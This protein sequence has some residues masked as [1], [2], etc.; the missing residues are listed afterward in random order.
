MLSKRKVDMTDGI[1]PG[2]DRISS[3]VAG[4]GSV[5]S[6]AVPGNLRIFIRN[7]RVMNFIDMFIVVLLIYAVFIGLRRGLIL[8]LASLAALL[9]GVYA[10][11]KLSGIT[12]MFLASHVSFG[13]EYVYLVS[14]ALTFML[15]FILVNMVGEWVDNL[16][17]TAHLSFPNK[18]F[19]AVFNVCKVMLIAG[20]VIVFIDRVDS[21]VRF[22]PEKA[23]TESLFYKP[24]TTVVLFLFPE[25]GPPQDKRNTEFV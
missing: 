21:R 5:A 11:L 10:A 17:D 2:K 18:I 9:A 8:Q 7:A 23:R 25:L 14:V 16:V 12:A 13:F 19:G 24:V 4:P 6:D 1:Y 22:V 15:V 20:L 3:E